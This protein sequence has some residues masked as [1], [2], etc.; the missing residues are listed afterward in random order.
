MTDSAE[1]VSR[2]K[3]L[4]ISEAPT[5][6]VDRPE[7][8]ATKQPTQS[9]TTIATPSWTFAQMYGQ[10]R[11]FGTYN[12]TA[13]QDGPI[14]SFHHC[15]AHIIRTF[16]LEHM[17]DIFNF[18]R[19]TPKFTIEI[20][21]AM[22]HVGALILT[23]NPL[24]CTVDTGFSAQLN[25]TWDIRTDLLNSDYFNQLMYNIKTDSFKSRKNKILLPHQL[26]PL[27]NNSNT[28][29]QMPWQSTRKALPI[30]DDWQFD[31]RDFDPNVR[32][33][34]YQSS[35]SS[36]LFYPM[37]SLELSIYAPLQIATGVN[38]NLT[39]RVWVELPDLQFFGYNPDSF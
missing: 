19:A 14:F 24:V 25:S 6:T 2:A 12:V 37:G 17:R 39:V 5:S 3:E 31:P 36:L 23:Y 27:G 1:I 35:F 11:I 22:Q 8:A 15:P 29:Y 28:V 30:I 34:Y 4:Q 26:I 32:I 9:L 20:Q 33:P 38:P 10:K 16:D 13:D 21:S 18:Y 7:D